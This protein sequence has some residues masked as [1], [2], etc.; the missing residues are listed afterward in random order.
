MAYTQR[1]SDP[2]TQQSYEGP[3]R[4]PTDTQIQQPQSSYTG[5]SIVDYLKSVGQASDF[6]S[7]TQLAKQHG[8]TNYTGTAAQN[9]QLLNLLRSRTPSAGTTAGV[10]ERTEEPTAK[11]ATDRPGSVTGNKQLDE[12]LSVLRQQ[13]EE[14]RARGQ[15]VNPNIEIT[16][17]RIAQFLTQA[18]Q[19]INPY[20]QSQ[21][22]MAKEGY[23]SSVG[24]T[25]DEI[26]R[27][28]EDLTRKFK[29]GHR[30]LGEGMAEQGFTLSGMRQREERELAEGAQRQAEATRA[31]AA[32][33]EQQ[34][35]RQ[36]ASEWGTG[37][38][39]EFKLPEAPKF[40]ASGQ[41]I[42]GSR[43]LPMFQL[44]G[45]FSDLIGSR[46]FERRGAVSQ[47]QSQ[48]ETAERER[49][50]AQEARKLTL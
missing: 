27:L 37:A 32:F 45:G 46:E 40:T 7:R 16:P 6:S 35:A 14:M 25:R 34:R 11:E 41:V 2:I 1:W 17:E 22:K 19:E 26:L 44:G 21:L 10:T 3:Q 23:L 50:L 24:Y 13:M 20:Y 47:R 30:T 9:T 48:L 4:K 18:E 12:M 31:A 42:G 49:L 29:T 43:D 28:E 5:P 38:V 36:L 39:S 8:I 33:Q 15:S